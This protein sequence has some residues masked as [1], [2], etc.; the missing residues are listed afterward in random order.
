MNREEN[1]IFYKNLIALTLPLAFQSLMLAAVAAGD[2]FMLG[3][4]DQDSMSS[5]SLAS[6]IQFIQNMVIYSVTSAGTILGAQYW[7]KGDKK[8]INDV[9]CLMLRINAV[10]SVLFSSAACSFRVILCI[11]SR[12]RKCSFQAARNI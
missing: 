2:A 4:L 1:R 10:V 8:T 9:F 5:V 6:Q 11:Y 7:G 3:R 12:M